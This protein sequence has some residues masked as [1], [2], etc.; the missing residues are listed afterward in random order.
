MSKATTAVA[1][2]GFQ[3][4]VNHLSDVISECMVYPE[5]WVMDQHSRAMQMLQVEDADWS[6]GEWLMVQQVFAMD[7]AATDIYIQT[8]DKDMH[9]HSFNGPAV[10]IQPTIIFPPDESN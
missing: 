3:S 8:T 5:D 6:F 9:H 1:M 10:G 4:S 2:M 7:A